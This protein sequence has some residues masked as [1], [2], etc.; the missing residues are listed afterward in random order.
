MNACAKCHQKTI[1]GL[2]DRFLANDAKKAETFRNEINNQL[3]KNSHLSNPYLAR[4]IHNLSKKLLNTVDLYKAEKTY[5]NKLLGDNYDYWKEFVLNSSA[6]FYNALRLS[7]AGNIID[8]GAATV[9]D[10]I[11]VEIHQLLNQDLAIDQVSV[12]EKEI[13]KSKKILFLGDNAGEIVFDKLLIEFINHPNLIYAVRGEAI[14][15]DACMEDALQTGLTDVCR[16][17]TNGANAP[18]TLLELCSEEFLTHYHEADLIISKGMGNFEGLMNIKDKN[19]FF[20]LMAKCKPIADL[21]N[22]PVRAQVITNLNQKNV[23]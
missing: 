20:L 18:S 3:S 1:E 10:D 12:L 17:I 21:L 19:I 23:I 13:R 2:I 11:E 16:V 4:E 14:I 15:N 5:A 7:V 22:V 9:P 6:P 8:Y